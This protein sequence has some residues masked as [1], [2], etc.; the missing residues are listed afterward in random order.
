[1]VVYAME[2]QGNNTTE[3]LIMFYDCSL[4]ANNGGHLDIFGGSK[5]KGEKSSQVFDL[6]EKPTLTINQALLITVHCLSLN[7]EEQKQP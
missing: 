6:S 2:I 4:Y 1:M 3:T 5:E 7:I